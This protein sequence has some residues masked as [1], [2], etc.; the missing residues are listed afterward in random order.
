MDDTA[1][2]FD[3]YV[4]RANRCNTT[5]VKGLMIYDDN[6]LLVRF[7]GPRELLCFDGVTEQETHVPQEL[8]LFS[9]TRALLAAY[10]GASL[11]V[12]VIIEVYSIRS[13]FRR[14]PMER[15]SKNLEDTWAQ[16]CYQ[17]SIAA[18]NSV[19]RPSSS[20]MC[21]LMLCHNTKDNR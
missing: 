6:I 1:I 12:P 9:S 19:R 18:V 2:R 13:S 10:L 14:L 3:R 11:K 20:V 7:E 17:Y 5:A 8:D 16:Y 4:G 21:C 15:L